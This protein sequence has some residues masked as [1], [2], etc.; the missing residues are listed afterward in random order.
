M[1][2]PKMP[3]TEKGTETE[4]EAETGMMWREL[5]GGG[6]LQCKEK[7][8]IRKMTESMLPMNRPFLAIL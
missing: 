8:E 4:T 2:K 7:Q 6:V 3:G 5:A 1:P